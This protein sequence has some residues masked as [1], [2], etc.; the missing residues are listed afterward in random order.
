MKSKIKLKNTMKS[1]TV[2]SIALLSCLAYA[3]TTGNGKEN[4]LSDNDL[5]PVWIQKLEIE[6][7]SMPIHTSGQFTTNDETFLSF[8]TGGIIDKIFVKEGDMILKGQLLATLKFNEIN[9][10]VSQ[11]ELEFEKTKR[12]YERVSN[13]YRDSVVSLEQFQDSKTS[14][15]LATQQIAAAR[16]NRSYSEIRALSDGHVLRKSASEGQIIPPGGVVLQTTGNKENDWVLKVGISDREWSSIA[17]GDPASITIDA[18]P[19]ETFMAKVAQKSSGIDY[20]TGAFTA[21]IRLI[22]KVPKAMASGLF[23]KAV[24]STSSKQKVWSIP[25]DALLDAGSQSGFVFV[26]NDMK[27]VQK[28]QVTISS[29]DKDRI[30]ISR[31][32]E[33]AKYIVIAGSAYLRDNSSILILIIKQTE[34]RQNSISMK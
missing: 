8:K 11:A 10:Q 28:Q 16:F 13:L 34:S 5:T 26:T 24:I 22:G 7:V 32:L 23:G 14:L 21:E 3:C 30:T 18:L 12:N 2:I 15:D 27:T 9:A 6:E 25:Y 33:N 31:G 19:G 17:L 4:I 29:I 1:L 20:N